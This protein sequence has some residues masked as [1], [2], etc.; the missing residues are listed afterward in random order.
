M[1]TSLTDYGRASWRRIET[2]KF[3]TKVARSVARDQFFIV[4][5]PNDYLYKRTE[6]RI[7]W[8]R[9]NFDPGGVDSL[10]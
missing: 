5:M 4:W 9:F 7:Q 10:V 3:K 2:K 6:N 8:S 1:W